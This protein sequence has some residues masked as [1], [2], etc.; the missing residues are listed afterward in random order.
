M[1]DYRKKLKLIQR[2]G[3]DT[4]HNPLAKFSSKELA[5]ELKARG[6]DCFDATLPEL[7]FNL[8]H[9]DFL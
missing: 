6:W 4:K 9:I 5:R 7:N 2:L 1:A 8:D 3:E